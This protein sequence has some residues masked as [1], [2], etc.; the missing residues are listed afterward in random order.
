MSDEHP[1]PDIKLAPIDQKRPLNILLDDPR[2]RI[3][4]QILLLRPLF[5]VLV[6]PELVLDERLQLVQLADQFNASASVAVG[7]LEKPQILLGIQAV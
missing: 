3:D 2:V 6:N 5:L 7:W 1:Q 4:C